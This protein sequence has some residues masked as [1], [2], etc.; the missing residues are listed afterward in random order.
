MQQAASVFEAPKKTAHD[1]AV[2]VAVPIRIPQH[3]VERIVEGSWVLVNGINTYWWRIRVT[4]VSWN[5]PGIFKQN[6]ERASAP[7]K[8]KAGLKKFGVGQKPPL[9]LNPK[10]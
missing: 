2:I 1:D 7:P 6:I 10:P 9:I 8:V 3:H 5:Y 4:E